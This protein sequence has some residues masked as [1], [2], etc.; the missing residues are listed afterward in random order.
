MDSVD[1]MSSLSIV[2][3]QVVA[4]QVNTAMMKKSLDMA[5][6]QGQAMVE[7]IESAGAISQVSSK[8]PGLGKSLDIKG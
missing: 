2:Q 4:N 3:Q 7:L 5:K 1:A 6:F 8:A